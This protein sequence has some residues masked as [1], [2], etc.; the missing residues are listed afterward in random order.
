MGRLVA[1]G[2]IGLAVFLIGVAGGGQVQAQ[3]TAPPGAA[4]NEEALRDAL[5]CVAICENGRGGR[6]ADAEG[7]RQYQRCV[8]ER[9]CTTERS[10]RPVAREPPERL[11][12]RPLDI[13]RGVTPGGRV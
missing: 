5:A 10:P 6:I 2:G 8:V 11:L 1:F 12:N 9:H 3:Q 13:L 7:R 4:R